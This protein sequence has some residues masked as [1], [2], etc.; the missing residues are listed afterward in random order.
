MFLFLSKTKFTT[1]PPPQISDLGH[2]FDH[3]NRC[4][5]V[6][7]STLNIKKRRFEQSC[8]NPTFAFAFAARRFLV[9]ADLKFL[10]LSVVPVLIRMN[11]KLMIR[12]ACQIVNVCKNSEVM[13][14][15][16]EMANVALTEDKNGLSLVVGNDGLIL[17]YGTDKEIELKYQKCSFDKEINAAGQTVMPGITSKH[18]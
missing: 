5:V 1:R 9:F 4:P 15:G 16:K 12:H 13:L 10:S 2:R 17:D 14:R 18:I 3:V 7:A 6:L 8:S 11:H